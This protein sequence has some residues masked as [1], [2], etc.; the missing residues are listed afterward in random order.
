MGRSKFTDVLRFDA[1]F[2][3]ER[4]TIDEPIDAAAEGS[5]N[6]LFAGQGEPKPFKGLES[7]A[8][9]G[10]NYQIGTFGLTDKAP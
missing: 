3:L 6:V 4:P 8:G 9:V 10:G 7:Q 2:V 1:G 5:Q